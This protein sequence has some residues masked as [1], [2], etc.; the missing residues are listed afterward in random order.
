M[1]PMERLNSYLRQLEAR[2][3]LAALTRGGAMALIAA[4]TA[5]ILLV[6]VMNG[7]AF[8]DPSVQWARIA[9]FLV[10][11]LVLSL[12]IVMPLLALNRRM[13]ARRAEQRFPQF[14]ERLLTLAESCPGDDGAN[15]PIIDNLSG[16]CH[17]PQDSRE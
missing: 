14:K 15:C 3:R 10:L 9:L 8:S 13:A 16:C 6:L 4:A 5:T 7:F 2:L 1:N 17:H 12:G 11:A